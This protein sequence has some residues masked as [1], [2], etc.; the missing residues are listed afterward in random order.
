MRDPAAAGA[1]DGLEAKRAQA[2]GARPGASAMPERLQGDR[3]PVELELEP[4][5]DLLGEAGAGESR[6]PSWYVGISA[7]SRTYF[8]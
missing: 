5:R 8:T 2:A 4:A 6:S 3:P 7:R 1:V